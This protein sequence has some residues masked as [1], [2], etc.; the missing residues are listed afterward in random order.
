[1]K[2]EPEPNNLNI[3]KKINKIVEDRGISREKAEL[4]YL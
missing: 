3:A 1:M 2:R 4:V